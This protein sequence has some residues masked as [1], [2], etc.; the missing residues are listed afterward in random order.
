MTDRLTEA[1][2]NNAHWCDAVCR[3]HGV[4]TS[5][6]SGWWTARR[7]SPAF[8]PDAITLRRPADF[9]E[10]TGLVEGGP[11]CSVKDSYAE[12]DLGP[13]GFEPLLQ[14]SWLTLDP[15]ADPRPPAAEA[16]GATGWAAIRTPGELAE[17][18]RAH[19]LLDTFRPGL[20]ADPAVRFLAARAAGRIV[21]GA[22]ANASGSVVGISNVFG[23]RPWA[24][25]VAAAESAFPGRP[26]VGYERPDGLAQ[27]CSVGFRVIG[28]LRVWRRPG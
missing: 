7:R 14:A 5:W 8:Y 15:A 3:A 24:G 6:Q 9:A 20:L 18:S 16:E 21:A 17:W 22:I 1:V 10:V 28:T 11:D 2:H 23:E 27:P 13:F 4:P 19:G 26:L 25:L 12:L